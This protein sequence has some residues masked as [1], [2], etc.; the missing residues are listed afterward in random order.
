[1]TLG[2]APELVAHIFE[3]MDLALTLL[4]ETSAVTTPVKA[5]KKVPR[6]KALRRQGSTGPSASELSSRTLDT[7]PL[8]PGDD[9][10]AQAVITVKRCVELFEVYL[11]AYVGPRGELWGE[12]GGGRT[13]VRLA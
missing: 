5:A 13:A 9:N 10:V 12:G 8:T 2:Q 4:R 11:A 1:M 3:K 7:A 6:V